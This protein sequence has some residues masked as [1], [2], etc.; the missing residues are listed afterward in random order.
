MSML[1]ADTLKR[2]RT[3]KGLSQREL[4]EQMYVNRSTVTRWENGIRLPDATMISRLSEVLGANVNYLLSA[5]T[6]DEES[7][8]VIMVDDSKAILADCLPILRKVMPSATVTGFT[9]VREAVTYAKENRVA[10]AFMDFKLKNISGAQLCRTLL[11]IN[12]RTNVVFLTAHRE[13]A[14]EAWSTGA[15]GFMLKPL[16]PEGAEEQ[17]RNL[18][19][20]FW[21][22]D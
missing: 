7:P 18:R 17:L 2:L 14:L 9:D 21:P 15:S 1:F 20:P 19:Y 3:E 12:P 5:A 16:T 8:I 6:Q 11:G 22:G 4:A 10:L 13:Y